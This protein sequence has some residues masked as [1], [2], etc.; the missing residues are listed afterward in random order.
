MKALAIYEHGGIDKLQI[1]D[2]PRPTIGP[3][4]VL[5]NVR[6]IALNRLDLFVRNGS[7]A[8][9]L[10]MPHIPGSDAAGVIAEVGANVRGLTAGQHVTVNP[11]LS[12]GRCEFCLAGQQSLCAEFQILGEHL[13]GAAA[14]FVRV[15]AVNVLPIPAD[16]PF[17]VAAAAPLV[18]LT[19]WRALISRARLRPGEDVLVVG[20]GAGTSTAAI[21]IAKRAGARVFT[22]SSTDEK[23]KRAKEIGADVVLNYKTQEWDRQLFAETGKRGVDV[24][25]ESVGAATWLKSIRA[26]KRG[27][28]MVVIGATTGPHPQEEIAYIFWKQIDILGS[29]MSSQSEFRDVMKLVLRGELK[30]V[31]DTVFPLERARDAHVRL[32]SGEQFGKIV[33]TV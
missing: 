2:L 14:E 20:A 9:K 17:E 24:V 26:L 33:L 32:E 31:I 10:P 15:P 22:T 30:P 16:F 21:Q 19:A 4:D 18:Y 6:A 3:D 13:T 28:R 8:L 7:P 1:V 29:T 27:G 5:I 25:F 23:L 11:G 12:C